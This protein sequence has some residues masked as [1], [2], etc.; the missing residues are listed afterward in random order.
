[1]TAKVPS[2]PFYP[3]D[4]MKDP[5]VGLCSPA[6][7]G[8]WVDLLCAMHENDRS[9]EVSG[10]LEQLARAARCSPTELQAAVDEIRATGAGDVHRRGRNGHAVV[11]V[12][13]RRMHRAAQEH[14]DARKRQE[15]HRERERE[16][17]ESRESN[18]R[19]TPG[20][21]LPS[22]SEYSSSS[23]G[24]VEEHPPTPLASE[25]GRSKRKRITRRER[26]AL[27]AFAGRST[28][29]GK[30][31]LRECVALLERQ[32]EGESLSRDES[33]R[34][35]GYLAVFQQSPTRAAL[36]WFRQKLEGDQA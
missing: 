33:E 10:T 34:L 28:G 35:G 25:G 13:N 9:G 11:T 7:R 26:E 22:S 21:P 8:V 27:G 6:T 24:D 18:G 5:A 31:Y 3:G 20:K 15:A 17:V 1:M 14:Q 32:L 4:W 29:D 12:R 19:V 23:S 16:R 2:F 30:A 36:E